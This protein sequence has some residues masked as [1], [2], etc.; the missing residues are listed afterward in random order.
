M[1]KMYKIFNFK[2]F[3]CYNDQLVV[4][5]MHSMTSEQIKSKSNQSNYSP[6]VTGLF[7]PL[8]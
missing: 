5:V 6:F 7:P 3:L 4:I 2:L 1:N 8:A